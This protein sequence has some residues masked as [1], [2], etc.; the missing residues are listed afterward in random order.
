MKKPLIGITPN[1]NVNT[2]EYQIHEDYANAV[3]HA[4]GI[5]VLL[6]PETGFPDYVDAII[7]SGGGDIDPLLFG[8]E[9]I[10]QSGEISP[11]RDHY[12]LE[13]CK[14]ALQTPLPILGIC[15]GMQILNIAA[16]GTIYQDILAQTGS[17]LKHSQQA[18][19]A[20]GTHTI[21]VDTNSL[22]YQ[23][24]QEPQI[25]VNSVHHQAVCRLGAGFFMA[26]QSTDGLTEAIQQRD[27]DFVLGV[28]WHPEVMPTMEQNAIFGRLVEAAISYRATRKDG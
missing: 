21:S 26:A 20:Y 19:R 1:Y 25:V 12:E 17:I 15:R 4:G 10:L 7:L 22:L 9:P 16:G 3:L 14:Q 13:L 27:K 11:L 24:W 28:Q 2:K 5:P 8:E 18:P 23:L 6:F